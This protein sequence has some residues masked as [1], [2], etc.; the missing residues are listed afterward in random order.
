MALPAKYKKRVKKKVD[1]K[2]EKGVQ[3]RYICS[4][5]MGQH[6]LC[7][8]VIESDI[9]DWSDRVRKRIERAQPEIVDGSEAGLQIFDPAKKPGRES[10]RLEQAL[11]H[12]VQRPPEGLGSLHAQQF[13]PLK[14]EEYLGS[15]GT[16][17]Q[18]AIR[19]TH[20][21]ITMLAC[22]NYKID[23]KLLERVAMR[24]MGQR[25]RTLVSV[26]L[27]ILLLLSRD[28]SSC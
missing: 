26:L 5:P 24:E 25:L 23:C 6:L 14:R 28:I 10:L 16:P 13:S 15:E 4:W 12:G 19:N 22:L 20:M 7:V 3:L 18:M 27:P 2:S 11:L 9:S 8:R 1:A 17:K 21:D